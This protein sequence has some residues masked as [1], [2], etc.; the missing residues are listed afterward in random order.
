MTKL[1]EKAISKVEKLPDLEQNALAKW[2]LNEL[3]SDRRWDESFAG[4]EQVLEKLAGE[5]LA[6][7]K[8]K[9]TRSLDPRIL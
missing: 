4:S 3:S 5:A 6:E 7:H 8:I 2:L 1:L 9:K